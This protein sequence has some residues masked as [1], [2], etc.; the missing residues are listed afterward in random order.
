MLND[1]LDYLPI[2]A[3]PIDSKPLKIEDGHVKTSGGGLQ[4]PNI[5]GIPWIY[6]NPQAAFEEW[7]CRVQAMLQFLK[8]KEQ[9]T[10]RIE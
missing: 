1:S 3:S 8:N 4:F 6:G 10:N 5:Q 9:E 2:L 7:R